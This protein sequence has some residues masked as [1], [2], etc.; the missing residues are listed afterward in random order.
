ML[1]KHSVK[2]KNKS[3]TFWK[4]CLTVKLSRRTHTSYPMTHFNFFLTDL[5]KWG[6][7]VKL[8]YS[9]RQK[10][11]IGRLLFN[12]NRPS[13]VTVCQL[14]GE[15]W[16]YD[17]MD[18]FKIWAFCNLT[19][20]LLYHRPLAAA[21]LQT[22]TCDLVSSEFALQLRWPLLHFQ[23]ARRTV[24]PQVCGVPAS[25]G[26]GNTGQQNVLLL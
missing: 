5:S 21:G 8:R 7:G 9:M 4:F 18:S 19:S 23:T 14:L 20:P 22:A 24:M 2:E 17:Q 26:Y 3:P 13:H 10:Q 1:N 15:I 11:K 12:L 25:G 16:E 6:R